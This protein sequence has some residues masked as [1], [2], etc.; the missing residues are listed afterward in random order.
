MDRTELAIALVRA[1][2]GL[3]YL[4]HGGQKL[5][6][7]GIPGVAGF[8]GQIGIPLPLVAATVVSVLETAG[9]LA[10][11]VGLLTRPIAALLAI[12]ALTA[13]LV[14]HLPKGFFAEAGGYELVLMLLAGLV[15]LILAGPGV[16][17]LDR[18]V[19]W[20]RPS[21]PVGSGQPRPDQPD[22]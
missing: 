17:A 2:V 20:H 5:F 13:I 10:L 14:Y 18:L 3:I 1:M 12:D 21:A 15:A 19:T 6:Q 22:D 16:L 9:G 8:F 4:M 11:I 7:I